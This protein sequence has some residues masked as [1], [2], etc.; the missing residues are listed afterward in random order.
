MTDWIGNEQNI[1]FRDE[2]IITTEMKD[3]LK[4]CFQTE[5]SSLWQTDAPDKN[6]KRWIT[7]KKLFV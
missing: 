5:E 4:F 2:K 7:S 3:S 6:K 1:T